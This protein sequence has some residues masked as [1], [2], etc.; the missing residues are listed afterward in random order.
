MLS[1]QK[2]KIESVGVAIYLI[3]F[4]FVQISVSPIHPS[5]N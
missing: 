5:Y 2:L 1:T 3:S 4:S